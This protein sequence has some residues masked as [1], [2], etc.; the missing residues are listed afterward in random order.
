[1]Q[2]ILST[3]AH[4]AHGQHGAGIRVLLFQSLW[5]DLYRQ[6]RVSVHSSVRLRV[7]QRIQSSLLGL[8]R[9]QN[10]IQGK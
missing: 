1:M 9:R 8:D 3:L 2:N 7:F 5:P 4:T 6:R 10:I